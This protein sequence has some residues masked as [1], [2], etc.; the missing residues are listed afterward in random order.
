MN[1]SHVLIQFVV[2]KWG[3]GARKIN[4]WLLAFVCIA[5][6]KKASQQF[7]TIAQNVDDGRK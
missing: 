5:K 4:I 3:F 7:L 6:G 1:Y 2:V